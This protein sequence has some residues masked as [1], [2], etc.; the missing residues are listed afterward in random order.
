MA[1]VTISSKGQ[2]LIPA[3][4]RKALGINPKSKIRIT[5]SDGGIFLE[6]LTDNPIETLTGF[7][8]DHPKSLAEELKREREKDLAKEES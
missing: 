7:F 5:L 1:V 4:M 8:K 6:P 2:L 3:S